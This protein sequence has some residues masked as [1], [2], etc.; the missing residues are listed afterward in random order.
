MKHTD[1]DPFD[2]LLVFDP[3]ETALAEVIDERIAATGLTCVKRPAKVKAGEDF[4]AM[5]RQMI[6]ATGSI[7][8]LI[9]QAAMR[10]EIIP[11]F[12]G[13]AWAGKVPMFVLRNNVRL[14]NEWAYFKRFPVFS[15]WSGFPRFLKAVDQIAD[16]ATV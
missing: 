11:V 8:L 2:I 1:G 6:G 4:G 15:L 5:I 12:A 13:A 7:V 14:S 9:S 16:K 3:S 10:N